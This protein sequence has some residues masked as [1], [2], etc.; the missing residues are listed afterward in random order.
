MLRTFHPISEIVSQ[1]WLII[2]FKIQQLRSFIQKPNL[3]AHE[4][5]R[6]L[7]VWSWTFLGACT[8]VTKYYPNVG[9]NWEDSFPILSPISRNSQPSMNKISRQAIPDAMSKHRIKVF[10]KQN[11]K[12]FLVFVCYRMDRDFSLIS[13]LKDNFCLLLAVCSM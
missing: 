8:V 6:Y 5:V 3:E 12:I 9:Q 4:H 2:N 13:F 11:Q 7:I 1:K 10:T